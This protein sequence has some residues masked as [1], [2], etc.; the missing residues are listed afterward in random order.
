MDFF[1]FLCD[2]KFYVQ[3]ISITIFTNPWQMSE[4]VFIM[5]EQEYQK[6]LGILSFFKKG[7]WMKGKIH[8]HFR[9]RL[10]SISYSIIIPGIEGTDIFLQHMAECNYSMRSTCQLLSH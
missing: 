4:S 2:L 3:Y 10:G 8:R 1:C 9:S 5:Q 7:P 6:L